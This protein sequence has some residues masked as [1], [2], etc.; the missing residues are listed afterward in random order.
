MVPSIWPDEHG[1]SVPSRV[2]ARGL[3]LGGLLLAGCTTTP[4]PLA[5]TAEVL[6][7][8]CART[9]GWWRA[10]MLEGFCEYQLPMP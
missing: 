5:E 7:A 6:Q 2:I 8:R 4:I 10:N 1:R 3:A 9:G